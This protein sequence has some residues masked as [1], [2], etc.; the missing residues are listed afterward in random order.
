MVCDEKKLSRLRELLCHLDSVVVAY[1]G[2]VDST[3]LL[4]VCKDVLG[5]RVLAATADSPMYPARELAEAA[6]VAESLAVR[7]RIVETRELENARFALN[8]RDRCYHCKL[9]LFGRLKKIAEDEGFKHV[10]DG[11]N[12][13]DQ[14]DYRPGSVAAA[15]LGVR[16]PL[17]EVQLTKA[18]I[19]LLARQMGLSNWSKPSLACLATRFPY[20]VA[21]TRQALAMTEAAESF[22]HDLGIRQVRVR[23]GGETARIEVEPEEMAELLRESHRGPILTRFR[24]LGYVHVDLDLAGYRSGSMNEGLAI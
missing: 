13:D 21:I 19:R 24:E 9:E 4:R 20:G 17:Q 5:E 22:L 12:H 6:E 10:V 1:S 16:H 2:G 23:Y 15:E 14:G 3:L 8:P 11:S 7:H 18:E